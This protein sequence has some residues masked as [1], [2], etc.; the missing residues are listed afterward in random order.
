MG[1]GSSA[2]RPH[3]QEPS[4]QRGDALPFELV[5][6]AGQGDEDAQDVVFEYLKKTA[7]EGDLNA[8][9]KVFESWGGHKQILN[10]GAI[11]ATCSAARQG[12]TDCLK[13]LLDRG[14]KP[15]IGRDDM[16]VNP[17]LHALEEQHWDC[18]ELLMPTALKYKFSTKLLQDGLVHFVIS[19][20]CNMVQSVLE[21]GL[22]PS[23]KMVC[24]AL[25]LGPP[26][27]AKDMLA[28]LQKADFHEASSHAQTE[29]AKGWE[30][31]TPIHAA[32]LARRDA[33]RPEL[34]NQLTETT[35][36]L[37]RWGKQTSTKTSFAKRL[38][39]H[40]AA[41]NPDA[42]TSAVEHIA[43]C[44]PEAMFASVNDVPGRAVPCQ[45][46]RKH[47]KGTQTALERLMYKHVCKKKDEYASKSEFADAI[48]LAKQ[49][50][51]FEKVR[52]IPDS[53]LE[54]GSPL[55]LVDE[56]LSA[57]L[58]I[59]RNTKKED[60]WSE[61]V[62]YD[63]YNPVVDLGKDEHSSIKPK[64]LSDLGAVLKSDVWEL[65]TLV[66]TIVRNASAD[67]LPSLSEIEPLLGQ[68]VKDR[69]DWVAG[70]LANEKDARNYMAARYGVFLSASILAAGATRKDDEDE[71]VPCMTSLSSA[72][73][74]LAKE[75]FQTICRVYAEQ[76]ELPIAWD[77]AKLL[78]TC[79]DADAGMRDP[80]F[81]AGNLVLRQRLAQDHPHFLWLQDLFAR[82]FLKR[83]TRDRKKQP[84][85]ERLELCEVE[86][87]FNCGSWAEYVRARKRVSQ[88]LLRNGTAWTGAMRTDVHEAGQ[89]PSWQTPGVEANEHWLF[90][91]TSAAGEEGIA[92]GDFRL[93]LA[94]S[95]VG[96]LYGNGAYMAECVSKSDEYTSPHGDGLRS[97][98]ACCTSMGRVNYN[99][100]KRPDPDAMKESCSG[101]DGAFHSVLGD[102]EKIRGTYREIVLFNE[103]FVYAAFACRYR[104]VTAS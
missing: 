41:E 29:N 23:S 74:E 97:I 83:Y 80:V 34:I 8:L 103:N 58:Q 7:W 92:E 79:T 26:D 46:A 86:Q 60:Y 96:T 78:A 17:L 45:C 61:V 5:R 104:R 37:S 15:Y 62:D 9:Q 88:E 21:R 73:T 59:R 99:D 75:S 11:P 25:L 68:E 91:G 49:A 82:T 38:P 69:L 84:V 14:V 98:L 48:R 40:Y 100:D 70:V 32:C 13:Y 95:N 51:I 71:H 47:S 87:I 72:V 16:D 33:W 39:L 44:Y 53:D 24:C 76:M 64:T 43:T 52:T 85:P 3:R 4:S 28:L 93:N 6:K 102:R 19:G 81:S 55:T 101:A 36:D 63:K 54:Q 31:F 57:Q 42:S 90:H 1:S 12:H 20:D 30:D 50:L 56:L 27:K 10:R 89:P 35:C 67:A 2:S 18:I 77:L 66:D 22:L 65:L 94:G